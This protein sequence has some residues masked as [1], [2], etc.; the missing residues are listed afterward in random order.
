MWIVDQSTCHKK[1]DVQFRVRLY[2][3][4]DHATQLTDVAQAHYINYCNIPHQK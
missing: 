1:F 3:M 2:L 4:Y